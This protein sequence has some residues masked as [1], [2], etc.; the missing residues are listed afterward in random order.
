MGK[1]F[2]W[3]VVAAFSLL[4]I[5][6]AFDINLS[7]DAAPNSDRE[8]SRNPHGNSEQDPYMEKVHPYIQRTVKSLE[9][10]SDVSDQVSREKMSTDEAAKEIRDEEKELTDIRAGARKLDPTEKMQGFH[11]HYLKGLDY[12][13]EGSG[14]YAEALEEQDPSKVDDATKLFDKGNE[15]IER[16]SDELKDVSGNSLDLKPFNLKLQNGN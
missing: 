5:I 15:E 2:K 4:F 14:L 13:V 9:K 11:D 12:Y 10:I 16:A 3:I 6:Y 1:Y 7:Q 8:R